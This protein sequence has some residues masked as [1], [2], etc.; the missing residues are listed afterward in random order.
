MVLPVICADSSGWEGCSLSELFIPSLKPLTAPPRSCPML[1][2]FLVPKISTTTSNTISQCQ[3]LSPP[4]IPPLGA[5]SGHHP[6]Q[7][8]RAAENV[9]VQMHHFLPADASRVDDRAIAVGQ[10][11]VARE[12]PAYCQ[13]LS[14]HRSIVQRS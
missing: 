11:L 10:A 1:R 2:S 9:H 8:L 12:L 5:R 7:R 14:Q 3:M 6:A 13:H 4:I